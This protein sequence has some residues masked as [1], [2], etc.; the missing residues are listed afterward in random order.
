MVSVAGSKVYPLSTYRVEVN[1]V[2]EVALIVVAANE[3]PV[4]MNVSVSP[5]S[6]ETAKWKEGALA[7]LEDE[8]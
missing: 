8:A 1:C 3:V 6:I 2:I 4:A 5:S 7:K